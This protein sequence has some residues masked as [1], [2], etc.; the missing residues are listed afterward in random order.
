M[1]EYNAPRGIAV[2]RHAWPASGPEQDSSGFGGVR[3]RSAR[4]SQTREQLWDIDNTDLIAPGTANHTDS[5]AP[6]HNRRG[7]V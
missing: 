4:S 2:G 3:R 1:V 5:H 7:A 6:F